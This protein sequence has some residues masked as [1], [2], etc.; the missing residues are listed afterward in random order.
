M[1]IGLQQLAVA[2]IMLVPG[3]IAT[4]IQKAFAPRRFSSD[5]HWT[6]SSLMIALILNLVVLFPFILIWRPKVFGFTLKAVSQIDD[7][8]ITVVLIYVLILYAVAI[9][10]GALLGFFPKL[11]LRAV[12]NSAGLTGFA[13][14]PSVWDRIFSKRR[15]P[16][17]PITW[18]CLRLG[19]GHVL[20][21]HLRHSSEYI[22][23]DKPFE[24]YL[25]DP[26]EWKD[27]HWIRLETHSLGAR[28]DGIY[29]R[30]LP[31]QVVEFYFA[32]KDWKPD[33][34]PHLHR[35]N[36]L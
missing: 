8:T 20:L 24:V 28:A 14:D 21:G 19:D 5:L 9:A 7:I 4:S 32:K 2:L 15:P 6:V 12:L 3:F 35:H 27:K 26:Y 11:R 10:L 17:R 33:S 22:D 13:Q 34:S 16:D 1:N 25:E 36:P 31:E 18:L 30:I 29:T 23:M